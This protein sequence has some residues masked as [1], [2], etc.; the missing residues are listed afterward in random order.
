MLDSFP[1][2]LS[3]LL[4]H[5]RRTEQ[6][7][8]FSPGVTGHSLSWSSPSKLQDSSAGAANPDVPRQQRQA[9]QLSS[10]ESLSETLSG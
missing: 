9:A 7:K 4:K 10:S 5:L 6:T 8:M 3:L 1:D 2:F